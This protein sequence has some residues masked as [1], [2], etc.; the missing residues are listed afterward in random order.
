MTTDTIM[1][2]GN[3]ANET[4]TRRI[5]VP[6]AD[7]YETKDAYVIELDLPGADEQAIEVTAENGVLAVRADAHATSGNGTTVLREEIPARHWARSFEIGDGIDVAGIKGRFSG[8]VLQL[9]LPKQETFK[10]R[11]ISIEAE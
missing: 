7:A 4:V 5:S 1:K 8:G 11:K 6:L 10:A 3:S 2:T 9:S